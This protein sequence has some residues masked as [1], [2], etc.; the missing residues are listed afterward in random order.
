MARRA[1][2]DRR[3]LAMALTPPTSKRLARLS[4]M[5]AALR[6]GRAVGLGTLLA[7]PQRAL[8]LLPVATAR[9]YR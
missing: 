4:A 9:A 7:H 2:T 3:T 6:G 1:V 8:A 5:G